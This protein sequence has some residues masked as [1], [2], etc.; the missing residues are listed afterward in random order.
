MRKI[1]EIITGFLP[2][3]I[4]IPLEFSRKIFANLDTATERRETMD[5]INEVLIDGTVTTSEW[6]ELGGLLGITRANSKRK[7]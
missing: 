6:K 1:L 7:K 4:R 3:K 5:F 2:P